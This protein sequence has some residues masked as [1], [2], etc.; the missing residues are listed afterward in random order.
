MDKKIQT[1][2]NLKTKISQ[3]PGVRQKWTHPSDRYQSC[4]ALSHLLSSFA[5]RKDFFKVK[6]SVT[7]QVVCRAGVCNVV[8]IYLLAFA[9]G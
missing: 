1:V 5:L 7:C 9:S 2:P 8:T 4:I 3:F 6:P